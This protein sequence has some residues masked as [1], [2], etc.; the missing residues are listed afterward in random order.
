[1]LALRLGQHDDGA[2]AARIA[3]Q[4]QADAGIAGRALDDDAAGLQQ[5]AFLGVLDDVE[6]GAILDR[7]PRVQELGLAEDHAPRDLRGAAQLDQRRVAERAD[8][9]VA[10]IHDSPTSRRALALMT[11]DTIGPR[12][13]PGKGGEAAFPG[14][15]V[16][17]ELDAIACEGPS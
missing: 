9:P 8:K 15:R 5:A 13:P 10:D 17:I 2:V 16:G 1:F 12:A 7:A 6:R 4:R 3:D 11:L 14:T